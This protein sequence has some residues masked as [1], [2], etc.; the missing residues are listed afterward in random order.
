MTDV[1]AAFATFTAAFLLFCA[2]ADALTHDRPA[3]IL[4]R[5]LAPLLGDGKGTA[6]DPKETDR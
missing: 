4:E 6:W 1:L 3:R 2:L 5:L